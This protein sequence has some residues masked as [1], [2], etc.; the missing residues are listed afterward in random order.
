MTNISIHG[1]VLMNILDNIKCFCSVQ[2]QMVD[3]LKSTT[4]AFINDEEF[5]GESIT[6]IKDEFNSILNNDIQNYY[7]TLTLLESKCNTIIEHYQNSCRGLDLESE[8]LEKNISLLKQTKEN[9]FKLESN[10]INTDLYNTYKFSIDN[11]ITM[12]DDEISENETLLSNLEQL[13]ELIKN[14]FNEVR[15]TSNLYKDGCPINIKNPGMTIGD[16]TTNIIGITEDEFIDLMQREY[17][18]SSYD[19]KL[20][21]KIN[22]YIYTHEPVGERDFIMFRLLGQAYY[23]PWKGDA[24]ATGLAYL[25][26]EVNFIEYCTTEVGLTKQEANRIYYMIRLQHSYDVVKNEVEHFVEPPSE[27]YKSAFSNYMRGIN[28]CEYDDQ[29]LAKL[30]NDPIYRQEFA[31]FVYSQHN[32]SNKIDFAH[33]M[34]TSAVLEQDNDI[35]I[36]NALDLNSD[37]EAGWYGDAVGLY[38]YYE[39]GASCGNDDYMADLDAVNIHNYKT[40]GETIYRTMSRYYNDLESNDSESKINRAD[41]FKQNEPNAI[42]MI[43]RE[44]VLKLNGEVS[45]EEILNIGE[46]AR[47]D[48]AYSLYVSSNELTSPEGSQNE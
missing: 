7:D 29:E 38:G 48:F 41:L 45:L 14:S 17:G 35:L 26:G 24:G 4:L 9:I 30:A 37:D 39:N 46:K 42:K 10:L 21:Y 27:N 6:A 18:F 20:L 2:K 31:D 22:V 5:E 25:T 43:T 19:A 8:I 47:R 3:E 16:S 23:E 12:L 13:Y 40:P 36:F 28:N 15:Q 11:T 32:F 1:N 44:T 33:F 34:I